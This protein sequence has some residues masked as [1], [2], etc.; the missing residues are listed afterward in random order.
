EIYENFFEYLAV[1]TARYEETLTRIDELYRLKYDDQVK[2]HAIVEQKL[3]AV[4]DL[5]DA[6]QQQDYQAY[7]TAFL[8]IVHAVVPPSPDKEDK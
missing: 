3:L 5:K 1:Q 4:K 8:A 6:L 2:K 7:R